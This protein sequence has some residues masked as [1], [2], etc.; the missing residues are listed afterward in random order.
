MSAVKPLQDFLAPENSLTVAASARSMN[1]LINFPRGFLLLLKKF[2]VVV[3]DGAP[4]CIRLGHLKT[5][6]NLSEHLFAFPVQSY[7]YRHNSS[8]YYNMYYMRL[9]VKQPGAAGDSDVLS[10]DIQRSEAGGYYKEWAAK[11]SNALASPPVKEIYEVS[12]MV[13]LP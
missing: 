5:V 13:N 7:A 12:N 2:L 11:L 8:L 1:C 3:P 10:A 4:H 6:G 9:L